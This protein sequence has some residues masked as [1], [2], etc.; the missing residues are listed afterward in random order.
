MSS[1]YGNPYGRQTP[2]RF[3]Q[4]QQG[5]RTQQQPQQAQQQYRP[6]VQAQSGNVQQRQ[7][8]QQ[9][10]QMPPFQMGGGAPQGQ[11]QQQTNTP[12]QSSYATNEPTPEM[13]F[14]AIPGS[15]G[16]IDMIAR[17]INCPRIK[18]RRMI[19]KSR[20]LQ[21]AID[22]EIESAKEELMR[23]AYEEGNAGSAQARQDFFKF[24]AGYFERRDNSKPTVDQPKVVIN[25]A[26]PPQKMKALDPNTGEIVEVDDLA[27]I[28]P[29]EEQKAA[30]GYLLREP[31]DDAGENDEDDNDEEDGVNESGVI[32]YR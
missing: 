28:Q 11:H 6:P 27:A 12:P 31:D 18:V 32:S 24:A 22:D 21:E 3:P 25:I 5:Q 10:Q 17:M 30:E 7:Q 8:M 13:I 15:L 20:E 1:I 4:Y 29:S 19:R 26:A 9:Q 2:Q 16:S 14:N 23:K